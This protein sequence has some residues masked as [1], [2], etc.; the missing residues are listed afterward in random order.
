M[1]TRDPPISGLATKSRD[2]RGRLH[3]HRPISKSA[4]L[5][6]DT[7]VALSLALG[8]MFCRR[9]V[10]RCWARSAR[11]LM[12]AYA[13]IGF[14]VLSHPDA[15]D[16]KPRAVAQRG[17]YAVVAGIR[18]AGLLR[19]WRLGLADGSSDFPAPICNGGMRRLFLRPEFLPAQPEQTTL[20]NTTETTPW[21]SFCWNAVAEARPDGRGRPRQGRICPQ[22]LLK[23]GKARG[24]ANTDTAAKFEA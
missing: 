2:S 17:T 1:M 14:A 16:E 13:L 21:K 12:M 6:G 4:A 3:R 10:L 24:A 19:W 5:R 8:I 7:L 20:L 22:L 15:G 18:L 9:T 11:A 23:R